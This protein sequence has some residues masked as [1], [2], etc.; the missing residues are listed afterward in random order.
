[1]AKAP[2]LKHSVRYTAFKVDEKDS[3]VLH[4]TLFNNTRLPIALELNSAALNKVPSYEQTSFTVFM[5]TR[6]SIA[7]PGEA[8]KLR[9]VLDKPISEYTS[10]AVLDLR[11]GR[12]SLGALYHLANPKGNEAEYEAEREVKE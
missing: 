5:V 12:K 10:S 11:F 1:M 9:V 4:M 3:R 7:N 8:V 2:K 6:R